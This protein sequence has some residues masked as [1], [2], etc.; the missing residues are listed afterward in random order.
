MHAFFVLF[1]YSCLTSFLQF[2][3]LL[4]Y[5]CTFYVCV[6]DRGFHLSCLQVTKREILKGGMYGEEE[7]EGEWHC[8]Q[9]AA[10]PFDLFTCWISLGEYS[11]A[12]S[13]LCV[14]P[15]SHVLKDFFNPLKGNLLPGD[16]PALVKS[17]WPWQKGRVGMGDI[18]LFN[19]KTVHGASKNMSNSFRLSIDTRVSASYFKPSYWFGPN[20]MSFC[21]V[22]DKPPVPPYTAPDLQES[23]SSS[24]S[25]SSVGQGTLG[26]RKGRK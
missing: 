5:V 22:T 20:E 15:G 12:N 2:L 25:S 14:L 18:I 16:Y 11:P 7:A 3:C 4:T 6:L 21:A 17:K 26:K 13:S 24:S 9:C 23:S 8:Q 10:D 19:V 1:E